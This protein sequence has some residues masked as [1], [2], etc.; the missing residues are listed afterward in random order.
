MG[1]V[2][3]CEGLDGVNQGIDTTVSGDLCRAGEAQGW[4]DQGGAGAQVLAEAAYLHAGARI[5]EDQ[6]R[7]HLGTSA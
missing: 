7:T 3:R 6:R 2:D 4:I 1:I 5:C